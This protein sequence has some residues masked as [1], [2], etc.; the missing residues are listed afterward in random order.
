M[1][2]SRDKHYLFN[3]PHNAALLVRGLYFVCILLVMLDFILHRHTIHAWEHVPVF[4][5]LFGFIACVAIVVTAAQLRKVLKR[6]E[7]YYDV[8]E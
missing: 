3:N 8:D 6:K 1:N 5:A 4:Y 7:D 2:Q